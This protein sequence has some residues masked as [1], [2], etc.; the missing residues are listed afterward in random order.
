MELFLVL[1]HRMQSLATRKRR[2]AE[3]DEELRAHIALATEENVRR[4]M[5]AEEARRQALVDFGGLAQ[6]RE[7]YRVQR[8]FRW[9]EELAR[10]LRYAARQLARNRGFSSTVILT[11]ALA[12]GVNTAAFSLVNALLL[13]RLPYPQP[14]QLGA[15]SM[16]LTGPMAMDAPSSINGEQWENLRDRVPS[17]LS[18][19]ASS[20]SEVNLATAERSH[21][22]R[23]ARISAHYLDVLGIHPAIGRNFTEEE[24]LPNGAK[25]ALLSGRLWRS[26]FN[27]D[28][29][30]VGQAIRLKGETY[31]VIGILPESTPAPMDT[32][33]YTPLRPSREGEGRGGNYEAIVRLRDGATWQQADAEIGRA[34]AD[35]GRSFAARNPGTQVSFHTVAL[36][37]GATLQL[38]PLVLGLLLA[39][40]F[41]LLIACA[42]LAG[43][44]LV[45]MERRKP[46]LATRLAL[47]AS[48]SRVLRQ[49]WVESLLLALLGGTAG[50]SV[51]YAALHG[52]LA[53]LPK[54][55]LPVADVPLDGHVLAFTLIASLLTSLLFGMLP[56]LFLRRFDLS[57]RL[58][59]RFCTS[60]P[61]L[62]L[63]QML[64]AGEVALTVVL[65]AAS[66]LLIRTLV[67]LETLPPGFD[68]KGVLAAKASLDD[69]R[70]ADPAAFRKLMDESLAAMQRI[71]GVKSAAVGLT[72]PYERPLNDEVT[73]RNGKE[74]GTSA[75]S[76]VIYTTPGYFETLGIPLLAGRAVASSDGPE[77]QHVAIV[78]L[79]FA[80]KFFHGENPLGRTLNKETMIVGMVGDVPLSPCFGNDDT[81]LDREPTMYI[82]A[83]Q[84][85]KKLLT[86]VHIWFEPSWIVRATNPGEDLAVAMQRT[87]ASVDPGLPF[88]GFYHMNDLRAK[89]L[90]V[91]RVEVAALGLLAGLALLL[92]AV[93]IFALVASLV[94]LRTREIGIR[95]ALG[96]SLR[97]A[98][99]TVGNS[100]VN[101]ALAGLGIGL[102]LCAVLL[103]AMRSMIFGI[104][105]YDMRTAA[106]VVLSLLL[107]V[108]L[109]AFTPA[110]RIA[111]I[112]P[113]QTLRAE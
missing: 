101:A 22:V 76:D 26:V 1:W 51:G 71:P 33:V 34:W 103:P 63:R 94:T 96:S 105:V 75:N 25:V 18:A 16:R 7:N 13:R 27:S 108:F 74:T 36:Q 77:T 24:D 85:D 45:R 4:G 62:R 72:L 99:A 52:L 35:V 68:A 82:P 104:E 93:G 48:M 6:T 98:I 87:L 55:F 30:L 46:E 14:E 50:V 23:A 37:K 11:L 110:L 112:D 90:Y 80:R 58:S 17:L 109:A 83:A 92:S 70:Y 53:L 32:E 56:A 20:A 47:G 28:R 106:A 81:P 3:L 61:R 79:A 29:N 100:G 42:N 39:T 78:N 89:T 64:I 97:E 38:R 43:L 15:I 111:R 113:A 88:S 73:I 86:L 9:L 57:E 60:H 84:V 69:V 10:D 40:G 8:G 41:I 107:V 95:I 66:G 2:D 44:M 54:H 91:Q 49:L 5:S 67:H 12:I 31:T 21:A 102:A 59:S 65:L 19:V